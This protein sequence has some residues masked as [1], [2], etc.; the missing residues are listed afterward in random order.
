[1]SKI[2]QIVL[3]I[4]TIISTGCVRVTPVS[5]GDGTNAYELSC[6]GSARSYADCRNKAAE[7]C[8]GKYKE[9]DKDEY[10]GGAFVSNTG[11]IINVKQ[12]RMTVVCQ[13]E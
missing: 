12:R 13:Y 10:S 1:M 6:P 11:M 4:I 8:G 3:V 9:L 7:I 2:A 5:L